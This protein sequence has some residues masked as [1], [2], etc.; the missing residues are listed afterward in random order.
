[1]VEHRYQLRIQCDEVVTAQ[2]EPR[3]NRIFTKA[4]SSLDSKF[5]ISYQT[6]AS[7]HH[8]LI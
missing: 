3:A 1:M 4:K 7:R 5:V 8:R 6:N 2:L